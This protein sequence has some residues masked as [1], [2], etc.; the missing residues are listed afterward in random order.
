ML[1]KSSTGHSTHL[2]LADK[3]QMSLW[4]W[5]K[6]PLSFLKFFYELKGKFPNIYLCPLNVI[7]RRNQIIEEIY[8]ENI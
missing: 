7:F 2:W 4:A 8:G 6:H 5:L 1:Q 3:S